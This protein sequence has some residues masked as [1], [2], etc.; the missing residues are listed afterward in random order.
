[1]VGFRFALFVQEGSLHL[2]APPFQRLLRH[3]IAPCCYGF[4][5]LS[6]VVPWSDSFQVITTVW[7]SIIFIRFL[8][9][10]NCQ[11]LIRL[12]E[13]SCLHVVI[14]LFIA[15][16]LSQ[17]RWMSFFSLLLCFYW[18][19]RYKWQLIDWTMLCSFLASLIF[20]CLLTVT[21]IMLFVQ[22]M[23][24]KGVF[25]ALLGAAVVQVHFFFLFFSFLFF[26][27]KK[28]I[29][30]QCFRLSKGLRSTTY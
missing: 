30:F 8:V 13:T 11:T 16:E 2:C 18:W 19:W 27:F 29:T 6:Q 26:F 7:Q 9:V 4:D 3:D 22:A 12:L 24:I 23:S 10:I 25:F 5:Y 17:L 15:V 21:L 20:L 1:M 14:N 28:I